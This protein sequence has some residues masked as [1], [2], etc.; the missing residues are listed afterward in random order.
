LEHLTAAADRPL[1]SLSLLERETFKA[2]SSEEKA[3]TADRLG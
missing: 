1:I 3:A 2:F